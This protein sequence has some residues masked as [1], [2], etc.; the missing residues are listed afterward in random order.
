M[1]QRTI[2]VAEDDAIV[3]THLVTAIKALGYHVLGPVSN[4][5]QALEC[6]STEHPDLAVLDIRLTGPL[7]GIETAKRLKMHRSIPVIFLTAHSDEETITHA[8]AIVGSFGY[9]LKPFD[10]RDLKTQIEI[11]LH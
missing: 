5:E 11:T 3:A 8:S 1:G 10:E 9:I 7:N 6:A 2:L 4:G